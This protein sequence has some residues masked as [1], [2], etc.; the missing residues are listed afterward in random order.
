MSVCLDVSFCLDHGITTQWWR[1]FQKVWK[2]VGLPN[3]ETL[4]FHQVHFYTYMQLQPHCSERKQNSKQ[5]Y[6]LRAE[7]LELRA[8]NIKT[9]PSASARVSMLQHTCRLKLVSILTCR[10]SLW[11]VKTEAHSWFQPSKTCEDKQAEHDAERSSLS[12]L[13]AQLIPLS[14]WIIKQLICLESERGEELVTWNSK[15]ASCLR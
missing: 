13:W 9:C 4:E 1:N 15:P 7:V 11:S 14:I 3:W 5:I 8:K 2:C 6:P 12:L 10:W